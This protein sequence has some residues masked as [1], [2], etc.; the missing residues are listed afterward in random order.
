MRE[1]TMPKKEVLL[2]EIEGVPE[3]FFNELLDFIHFLKAK[4]IRDKTSNAVLSES[5][6]KKDWLSPEEDKAWQDL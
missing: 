3:I 6:L 5:S 2:N 1:K 4:V